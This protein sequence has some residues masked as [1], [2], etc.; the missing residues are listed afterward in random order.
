LVLS[1]FFAC[2]LTFLSLTRGYAVFQA[3]ASPA[4]TILLLFPY[5][6][7]LP[8]HLI[9]LQTIQEEFSKASDLQLT[10]YV[11]Y[12]DRN[13]FTDAAYQEQ[14]FD[15]LA[16]KYRARPLDLVI[17]TD[18]ATLATWLDRRTSIV[19]AAPV[20]FFGISA[21]Q[22]A[23]L[24]LPP[25]VTGVTAEL[26]YT[27]TIAWAMTALP[28]L[29]EV[30]IV[31]GASPA[32]LEEGAGIE[33]M[34]QTLRGQVRFTDL[35]TLP[36]PEIKAH[37]AS[38]PKSSVVLYHL[39]LQD[40]AGNN[41]RPID[42][43][44]QLAAVSP[45]PILS[46]YRQ[47]VGA[48]ALGGSVVDVGQQAQSAADLALRLLRGEDATPPILEQSGQFVFD[49]TLLQRFGISLETLPAESVITNH[50]MTFWEMH[51]PQLGA[52]LAGFILLLLGLAFLLRMTRQVNRARRA[53]ATLNASLE[54]QVQERTAALRQAWAEA[55]QKSIELAA[56]AARLHSY[57]EMPVA[58]IAITSPEKG[59]L[60]MNAGLVAML[61]YTAQELAGVTWADLTYP[62]DLTADVTQFNRALAGEI[63]AYA[64]EKR[65]IRK[66]GAVIWTSMS[67][68][69]VRNPDRTVEYFV[70][71]LQEITERKKAEDALRRS[72]SQ[73]R[74]LAENMVDVIWTLNLQGQ[75]TYVSPSVERLRGY[76]PQEVLAQSPTEALTPASRQIMQ[77][78]LV[79][80]LPL[81]LQGAQTYTLQ[82]AG[83]ELEQPRKDGSTVWTE[84]I[85]KVLFDEEGTCRGFLGVSRDIAE[86]KRADATLRA[87]NQELAASN[88]ALEEAIA[89]ANELAEKAEAA[90][91][92][93][94]EFL[95]NMS[96]E[97][98]TPMN[99]VIGMTDL[100][101]GTDLTQEQR[102]YAETVRSSGEALL[103]VINDI[104]DFSKIEARKLD[105]Q[106]LDFDLESM[107]DDFAATLAYRAQEKGLE[108]L[109]S[110]DPDIPTQL[111]GDPGRLRQ[112]LTNLAG[113][114]IKFTDAGEVAIR[115]SRVVE[116]A[117]EVILR[118][119]V[120][121][122]GI[123][124]PADRIGLLFN[125]FSQIDAAAWRR[126][127]GTGLGLAIS[128]QLAGLMGGEIGVESIEGAGSRFWFTARLGKQP[129]AAQDE[130]RGH[131]NLLGAPVLIVDDNAT[132]CAMLLQ[133]LTAW[134]MRAVAVHNGAD[135]LARLH[136]AADASAPF[137]L[138]M[139]DMQMPEMDGEALCRL[140]KADARLRATRLLLMTS[141]VTSGAVHRYAELGFAAYLTKPLR[142]RE[143]ESTLAAMLSE[144]P[145]QEGSASTCSD[146]TLTCQPKQESLSAPAA[147][148]ASNGKFT[149]SEARILL[150][151][152]NLTNQKV[153]LGIL[154]KLGLPADAVAN[155]VEA[156]SAL[157]TTR[158]DLVLMDVHMPVMDGLE[159]TMRIRD[160]RSTVC[161]RS[162]PI[163][164][165]T[166]DAMLGDREKC[167]EAGMNDYITKPI[168][169]QLLS[170]RLE[171]WLALRPGAP[172][173]PSR[174]ESD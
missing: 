120:N 53:L 77:E 80:V 39:M 20:I 34:E 55:E 30:V 168:T 94:S 142:S 33:R 136:Q 41:H 6:A 67:V 3:P 37:V 115:V 66:D 44:R 70:A 85:V 23:S 98:R 99:G 133:R 139:L 59:W 111:C 155:G 117:H 169:P 97:I 163:I 161:D 119:E 56:S 45:V 50:E 22:L 96:H 48:G 43:L 21:S 9:A 153:A 28:A 92:A 84:A 26:D 65:F 158:Y 79:T 7:D 135:A 12:L 138:A 74:L 42:V 152:D 110:A 125:K 150:V 90:S 49:Y 131:A 62:D 159:A 140:I 40:A 60:E 141:L 173:P 95:A 124:V 72:E 123:G 134:G 160:P 36:L 58:G 71:L 2:L 15:L 127:G 105:L 47:F 46:G 121:D 11:E 146:V 78:S 132:H 52:I 25:D 174:A 17:T 89:R 154:R 145:A 81:A 83:F 61:G 54:S 4:K 31:R 10:L 113:N 165:M 75:F 5:Q 103:A 109:C 170:E 167:L 57:F 63:D 14:L 130:A 82:P 8:H 149:G 164:A 172:S 1:V 122:T 93:K 91:T 19:P 100:L 107:L 116:S 144:T 32:D 104:L 162:I 86:R 35:A 128:K 16:A 126:Y 129:G 147:S 102:Y 18:A 88:A 143:V 114:A 166:A 112:V 101:L 38:L 156:L 151:E 68:N 137:A 106:L 24:S 157:E 64:L 118:F 27:E 171:K 76:T 29:D 148:A 69:C 51:Q 108:L 73:Y 13:R 87:L